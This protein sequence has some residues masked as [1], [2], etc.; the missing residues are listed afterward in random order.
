[1]RTID[2]EKRMVVEYGIELDNVWLPLGMLRRLDEHG[3]WN[4]PFTEATPEQA[5]VLVAH[6]LAERHNTG[7]ARGNALRNFVDALPFAP[8]QSF[9][10]IPPPG[11]GQPGEGTGVTK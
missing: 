2:L 1:M 5:S 11:N 9:G 10:K 8:T 6:G 7:L 3:P 4:V